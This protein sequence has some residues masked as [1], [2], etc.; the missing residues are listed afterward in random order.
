MVN[1]IMVTEQ[2][3]KYVQVGEA[4]KDIAGRRNVM[5]KDWESGVKRCMQPVENRRL[6]SITMLANVY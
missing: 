5:S 3:V 4:G 1:V 6:G 2:G